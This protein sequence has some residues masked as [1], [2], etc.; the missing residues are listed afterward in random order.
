MYTSLVGEKPNVMMMIMDILQHLQF[1]K[2][3]H[4]L[5]IITIWYF[6]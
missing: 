4:I 2:Y 1:T 5:I 3:F 6:K